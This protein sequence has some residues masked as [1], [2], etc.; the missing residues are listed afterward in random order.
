[1]STMVLEG[2]IHLVGRAYR[3]LLCLGEEGSS[4]GLHAHQQVGHVHD[5]YPGGEPSEVSAWE[6]WRR[7]AGR[8]S[9]QEA[10]HLVNDLNNGPDSDGEEDGSEEVRVG[11]AP[12]P[13]PD[14]GR[15]STEQSER[16]EVR[17]V[18]P[19]LLQDRGGDAY[20]FGDV[21][22]GKAEDQEGPQGRLA[23]RERS[24][25]GE[26]LPQVVQSYPQGYPVGGREPAR[27]LALE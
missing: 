9:E 3:V 19:L 2:A 7:R 17:K 5:R 6:G 21:V 26:A 24:P 12:D 13:G 20:P 14:D 16:G 27:P 10:S 22:E 18:R 15:S 4:S 23:Q 8:V 25:D 1:M 11:E